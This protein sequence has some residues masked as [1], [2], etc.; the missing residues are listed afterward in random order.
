VNL[1]QNGYRPKKLRY[2]IQATVRLHN[3]IIT[4]IVC[5][6]DT[7]TKLKP[8]FATEWVKKIPMVQDVVDVKFEQVKYYEMTWVDM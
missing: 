7:Y 3:G 5:G 1:M 4:N 6:I 8:T 2:K